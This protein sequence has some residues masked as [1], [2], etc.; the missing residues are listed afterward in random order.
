MSTPMLSD[1]AKT[2]SLGG[3]LTHFEGAADDPYFLELQANAGGLE[4]LRALVSRHI[5][6]DAIVVDVGAHIGVSAIMLRRLAQRVIAFE[7]SPPNA[8]FLH[9]NLA[10]NGIT[11]VEP[12]TMA[13]SSD[14]ETLQFHV[15][16]FSA[17]SHV[18]S[19]GDLSR[20]AP[21]IEVPA[22]PLDQVELP[23]ISFIK[24]DAEGH[25]P[26]VLAGARQLMMRDRPLILMEINIWC[27]TAYADHNPGALI[28]QL[29]DR[30][31]VWAPTADGDLIPLDS[32]LIFLHRT[33]TETRG[34]GE[35]VLRP[36]LGAEMPT[37]PELSWPAA[38]IAALRP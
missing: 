7:P 27:L 3:V 18:M 25:E 36:R 17:G 30:F 6:R 24:I 34:G 16:Q 5:P 32:G 38:A 23:P 13:I 12:I 11:N 31:D 26:E 4:T 8:E 19:A 15:A 14:R 2:I 20:G 1:T 28:R 29:W 35:I 33:I 37:L 9:R 10:L 21:M 22:I